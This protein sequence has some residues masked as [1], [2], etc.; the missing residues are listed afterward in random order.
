[1]SLGTVKS[2]STFSSLRNGLPA[3]TLPRKTSPGQPNFIEIKKNFYVATC[4]R[5]IYRELSFAVKSRW[6][7]AR[8]NLQ[9]GDLT[10]ML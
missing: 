5:L 10:G 6:R 1:M 3:G 7:L 9:R 8:W 2:P 4:S